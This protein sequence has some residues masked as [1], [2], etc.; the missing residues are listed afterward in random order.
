QGKERQVRMLPHR[1]KKEFSGIS[2]M[3]NHRVLDIS[4]GTMHFLAR[5][6]DVLGVEDSFRFFKEF[7][8]EKIGLS[9]KLR[10]DVCEM[11]GVES[12]ATGYVIV[13]GKG[14]PAVNVNGYTQRISLSDLLGR[15]KRI[16][17]GNTKVIVK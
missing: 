4:K 3:G 2:Y 16:T 9:C 5:I 12:T 10:Q 17:D 8:Y 15:I 11:G 14:I 1:A 6:E 7:N 13:K